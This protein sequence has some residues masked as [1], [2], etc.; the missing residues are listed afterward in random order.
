MRQRQENILLLIMLSASIITDAAGDSCMDMG[1]KI[2]GHMLASFSILFLLS[3]IWMKGEMMYRNFLWMLLGYTLIRFSLF[4]LTYNLTNPD[5]PWHYI[6][7]TSIYDKV[8]SLWGG[9]ALL[10]A[11]VIALMGG[12]SMII[13]KV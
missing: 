6:G 4:D 10:F 13:R 2:M 7:S 8:M 11:R 1:D 3:S 5:L 12:V 9:K